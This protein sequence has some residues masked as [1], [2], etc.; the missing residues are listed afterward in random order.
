MNIKKVNKI[1][2]F[3]LQKLWSEQV[4]IHEKC[5]TCIRIRVI[6]VIT[7]KTWWEGELINLIVVMTVTFPTN[8]WTIS[9]HHG[10]SVFN[11]I[12]LYFQTI[13]ISM[14]YSLKT[15]TPYILFIFILGMRF[16]CCC[17]SCCSFC[18]CLTQMVT[19]ELGLILLVQLF[20]L[21]HF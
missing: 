13:L 6:E 19:K 9:F 3:A 7:N 20:N 4:K 1:I 2:S 16:C 15:W 14:Q 10:H 17:C 8:Y 5:S 21:Y 11:I 18:C 12:S